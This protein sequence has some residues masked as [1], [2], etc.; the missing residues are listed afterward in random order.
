MKKC[1]F[2]FLIT[3][4]GMPLAAE[5]YKG[6]WTDMDVGMIGQSCLLALR[7]YATVDHMQKNQLTEDQ[8]GEDFY[9]NL[10]SLI[11]SYRPQCECVSKKIASKYT[12]DE[13]RQDMK[14]I[15]AT[16]TKMIMET[17]ECGDKPFKLR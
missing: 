6:G 11:E 7:F 8:L 12:L 2:L 9:N 17:K 15:S 10:D 4:S 16:Y 14:N 13:Y 5:Q 1:V 3:L